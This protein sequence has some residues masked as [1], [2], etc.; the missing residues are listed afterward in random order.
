MAAPLGPVP[1]PAQQVVAHDLDIDEVAPTDPGS[2]DLPGCQVGV[3][4]L[5]LD[6]HNLALCL[7]LDPPGD[8]CHY[9]SCSMR[10]RSSSTAT[11]TH[12]LAAKNINFQIN[13]RLPSVSKQKSYR[14]L[15][16]SV[17]HSRDF[18][19]FDSKLRPSPSRSR[20]FFLIRQNTTTRM[21]AIFV[22]LKGDCL[23][24]VNLRF[25]Q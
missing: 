12:S 22:L 7:G 17:C 14:C 24:V 18:D 5:G 11:S 10:S 21:A 15:F 9:W 23:A 13:L 2:P 25:N 8:H 1:V 20:Q 16:R 19:C 6:A 3:G 4:V